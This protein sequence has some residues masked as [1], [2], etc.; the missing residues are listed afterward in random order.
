MV[1][2]TRPTGRRSRRPEVA[3]LGC[4]SGCGDGSALARQLTRLSS[5]LAMAV[6]PL[7]VAIELCNSL[8]EKRKGKK[9]KKDNSSL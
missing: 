8:G 3:V 7:V 6:Q 1:D 5:S 2:F 9:Q 4:A